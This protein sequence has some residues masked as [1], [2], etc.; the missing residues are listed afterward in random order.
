MG[1]DGHGGFLSIDNYE[2]SEFSLGG[3]GW[4]PLMNSAMW[5]EA[6]AIAAVARRAGRAALAD[7]FEA[8]AEG[9]RRALLEKCW[10]PETGFFSTPCFAA[11]SH[12]Q[13]PMAPSRSS[14][15]FFMGIPPLV[16]ARG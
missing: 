12:R 15:T 2:G 3:S 9:V 11:F 7:E 13:V 10:N 4:K 5:S 1:G 16:V 14:G 6:A 8:K